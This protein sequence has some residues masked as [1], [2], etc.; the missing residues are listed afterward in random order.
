M[1]TPIG[2]QIQDEA[3]KHLTQQ[4]S[5]VRWSNLLA[6]V[7][8]NFPHVPKNTIQG[9]LHKLLTTAS[10]IKKVTRGVY[11]IET[12]LP[13]AA[14]S[15]GDDGQEN[16]PQPA[17]M[18]AGTGGETAY[19]APF[20]EWL[21]DE[22]EEVSE[23]MALG[24]NLFKGKWG[25]PDVIGVLKPRPSDLIK[26]QPQI[27]SAEVKTDPNQTIVAF[28]QALSYRLFSNKSYIAVPAI[29]SP[30]D[31]DRL[32][33]LATITGIGLVTFALKTEM[34]DFHLVVR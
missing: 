26:F 34:P 4:V 19:Y 9:S 14:E 8:Q 33:A 10:D 27:V 3:R 7:G 11:A 17:H 30:D 6:V 22:L 24:G 20:A 18:A 5:G 21:R 31:L 2:K 16:T 28:G 1:T 12:P 23:V 32:E 25:T 15:L 13:N 29:T